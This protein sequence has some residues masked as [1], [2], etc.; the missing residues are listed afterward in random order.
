[1]WQA[2]LWR[3]QAIIPVP[4]LAALICD[5]ENLW[6]ALYI[7]ALYDCVRETIEVIDAKIAFAVPAALLI[8]N[9]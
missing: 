9:E 2:R 1:M 8:L 6:S 5:C 3:L 4:R 7:L